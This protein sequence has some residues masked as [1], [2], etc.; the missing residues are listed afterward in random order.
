[1]PRDKEMQAGVFTK[2]MNETNYSFINKEGGAEDT[3]Y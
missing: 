3:G 1:M 2:N